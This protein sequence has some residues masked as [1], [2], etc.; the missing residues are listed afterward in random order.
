MESPFSFSPLAR[1]VAQLEL[2]KID[3]FSFAVEKRFHNG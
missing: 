1:R 3:N 2:K